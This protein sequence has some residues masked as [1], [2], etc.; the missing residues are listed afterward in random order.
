MAFFKNDFVTSLAAKETT[1][2]GYLN[3][4]KLDDGATARFHILS[5]APIS[6]FEAWL[7]KSE[8][9]MA[10]RRCAKEPDAQLIAEWE[11]EIGGRIA[12]RD[13]RPAIKKFAAMFVW[14]YETD[15]VKVFAPTQI[16]VIRDLARLTEDP[17]YADLANWDVSI[18][19]TGKKEL[20]RYGV[21][22]K[23]TRAVGALSAR[24]KAAWDEAQANGADLG[25]LFTGGN[26]F[27]ASK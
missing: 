11:A 13:G 14:E 17:D 3:I 8:G 2:G 19:R 5:E 1:G 18:I 22:M 27:G 20:T 23:P 10:P 25:A 7:E 12:V 16:S 21:D 15:S 6:G 4:S 9:G 26:P 24:I